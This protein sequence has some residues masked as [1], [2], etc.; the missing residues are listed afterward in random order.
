M[1]P[2]PR[3][4]SPIAP[5]PSGQ[6]P[7]RGLRE[8]RAA[9]RG[10]RRPPGPPRRPG[11]RPPSP[12]RR[13]GPPATGRAGRAAAPPGRSGAPRP[14]GGQGRGP[15]RRLPPRLPRARRRGPRAPRPERLVGSRAA[16]G[17]TSAAR[18]L[19]VALVAVGVVAALALVA[20]V[21]L[22]ALRDSPV[23]SIDAVEAEPTGHVT[24]TDIQNLVKVPAGS[25]PAQR[26][27]R[28]HRGLAQEGSL[29]GRGE[30]R[31]VLSPTRSRSRSPSSR[32][33]RSSS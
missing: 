6:P 29:G 12:P 27:H 20:L 24:Q 17:A 13:P 28:R 30:L 19:R 26:G 15:V 21:A 25:T 31:A 8:G 22:F 32:S 2:T 9:R 5:A 4:K 33:T 7:R 14:Q 23:F 1:R 11:P 10:A 3:Q 16:P 18:A